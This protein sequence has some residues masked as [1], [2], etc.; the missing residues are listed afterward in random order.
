M[1][2]M[3]HA[4]IMVLQHGR[5]SCESLHGCVVTHV[6]DFL[7]MKVVRHAKY[8]V[9][10]IGP[11]GCANCRTAPHNTSI[12]IASVIAEPP[13]SL[14]QKHVAFNMFSLSVLGY[15]GSHAAPDKATFECGDAHS[16]ETVLRSRLCNFLSCLREVRVLI[17][18][19][20]VCAT[21]VRQH[22][23]RSIQGMDDMC[24]AF[25][26]LIQT[27]RRMRCQ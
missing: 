23:V 1:P 8:F 16:S 3:V 13:R 24:N 22:R 21:R 18:R 17:C 5:Q 2:R 26:F 9:T 4:F 12:R 7:D 19:R 25:F 6:P 11:E 15:I 10:I 27:A 14:T 20:A